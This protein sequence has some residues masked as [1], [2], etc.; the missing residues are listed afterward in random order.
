MIFIDYCFL[1]VFNI[2]EMPI[3]ALVTEMRPERTNCNKP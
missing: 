2:S 3:L 1:K